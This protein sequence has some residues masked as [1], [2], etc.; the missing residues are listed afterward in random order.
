MLRSN[1]PSGLAQ[2]IMEYVSLNK[3]IYIFLRQLN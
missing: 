2:A 3:I 1:R